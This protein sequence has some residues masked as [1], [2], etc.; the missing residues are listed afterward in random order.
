MPRRKEHNIESNCVTF[1]DHCYN[2]QQDNYYNSIVAMDQK[3]KQFIYKTG[4]K[5]VNYLKNLLGV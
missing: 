1:E 3:E 5:F 4:Q 2:E